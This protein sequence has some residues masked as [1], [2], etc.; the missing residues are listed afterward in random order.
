MRVADRQ[1]AAP[2]A[3][4]AAEPRADRP[5]A[6][7]RPTRRF[8]YFT[9]A[10]VMLFVAAAPYYLASTAVL[11]VAGF[12]A[13]AAAATLGAI[14][15]SGHATGNV[16]W[17]AG[18]GFVVTQECLATPLI[19]LY[20]AAVCTYARTWRAPLLAA[21]AVVPV[22]VALGIVRLLVVALPAAASPLFF[23]HA[24]YQLL[25]AAVI[26]WLAAAWRH[27]RRG[28]LPHALAG[29]T[30][31]VLFVQLLGPLF[32]H[33]VS[34]AA[35]PPRHDPQGAIGFLPTF[36]AGLYVA[37]WLAAFTDTGWRRFAAGFAVLA[38]SQSAGLLA[39]HA[40]GS[41][42]GITAHVRDIRGWAI[43][44]PLLVAAAAQHR[45]RAQH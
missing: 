28:A 7:P 20:F 35:P 29:I 11:A 14:G 21:L 13:R 34:Y 37:V 33:V 36:Q 38:I 24:F 26:V 19:P 45:A 31:G 4:R 2:R 17:T 10:F 1:A 27:G 15:V 39:L 32:L 16:L 23:V 40:L 41:Y 6:G 25:L 9:A 5:A 12:I 30:A 3:D 22:F 18:G 8:V 44:G 42:A 43:A